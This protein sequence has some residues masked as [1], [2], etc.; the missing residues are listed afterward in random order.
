MT[1]CSK[2]FLKLYWNWKTI[3][4]TINRV[5]KPISFTMVCSQ[6]II[7]NQ[8]IKYF[9]RF[10]QEENRRFF[11]LRSKWTNRGNVFWIRFG[12]YQKWA[13]NIIIIKTSAKRNKMKE[14]KNNGKFIG[15]PLQMMPTLIVPNKYRRSIA[16]KLKRFQPKISP[17]SFAMNW[18]RII[19]D[20]TLIR[21]KFSNVKCAFQRNGFCIYAYG[22]ISH[23]ILNTTRWWSHNWMWIFCRFQ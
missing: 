22:T 4:H 15:K 1:V 9:P 14:K 20:Y 23:D 13:S 5:P 3:L 2:Y 18:I 7:A 6:F 12:Y 10:V 21:I 17:T 16:F 19:N 11:M 8:I